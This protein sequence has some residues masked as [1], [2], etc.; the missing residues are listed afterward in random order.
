MTDIHRTKLIV[1]Q[2]AIHCTSCEK[3][4]KNVLNILSGVLAVETSQ[5]T[6]EV[7]VSYDSDQIVLERIIEVL[8]KIGFPASPVSSG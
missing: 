2:N 5:S 1:Q 7:V 3:R 6:Q 8:K 4:I